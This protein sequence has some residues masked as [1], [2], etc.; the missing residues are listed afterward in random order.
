MYLPIFIIKLDI[1]F[2]YSYLTQNFKLKYLISFIYNIFLQGSQAIDD[3][4]RINRVSEASKANTSI[5]IK[6]KDKI[7][8]NSKINKD[9]YLS[10]YYRILLNFKLI[11]VLILTLKVS[12]VV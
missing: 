4:S 7:L 12:K 6:D 1:I 2:L 11:K 5:N 9:I 8:I 10:S 3:N